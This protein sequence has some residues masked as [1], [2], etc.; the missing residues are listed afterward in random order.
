MPCGLGRPAARVKWGNSTEN[1][2]PVN[3]LS[4]LRSVRHGRPG[5]LCGAAAAAGWPSRPAGPWAGRG[6]GPRA[7]GPGAAVAR[8][9][10]GVAPAGRATAPFPTPHPHP[11]P[12]LKRN[13]AGTRFGS[14]RPPPRAAAGGRSPSGRGLSR[15]IASYSGW[16]HHTR[17]CAAAATPLT[18]ACTLLT[19]PPFDASEQEDACLF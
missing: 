2:S 3:G 17:K 18:T 19:P 11:L 7:R 14:P 5:L 1:S 12:A 16:G 9:V 10:M 4:K 13:A 6:R 15:R 8:G